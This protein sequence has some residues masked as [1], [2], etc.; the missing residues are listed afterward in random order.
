MNILG[1]RKIWY[2][3]S[4]TVIIIGLFFLVVKG[5]NFGIDFNGGSLLEYGF[6]QKVSNDEMRSIIADTGIKIEQIQQSAEEGLNGV[7]IRTR[8]LETEEVMKI[9]TAIRDAYPE[10]E[11]LTEST[12]GPLIGKE[13]R[14][15]A[16]W[17]IVIASVAIIIYISVR[18]E[19]RF[20]IVAIITLMHDVLIT[21]G[22]FSIMGKEINTA[23]VA[24]ILTI[25]GY[26]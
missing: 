11:T 6:E 8:H 9:K 7:I 2:T 23:F 4:M 12:V 15:N 5:L 1:R 20:A 10:F 26:S 22:L 19:F 24:A 3:I 18:F 13:L 21:L 14:T 17:A 25:I 16:L